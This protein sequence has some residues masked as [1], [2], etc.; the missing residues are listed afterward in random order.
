MLQL[1]VRI[2]IEIVKTDAF[3]IFVHVGSE[4]GPGFAFFLRWS[5]PKIEKHLR[6][7]NFLVENKFERRIWLILGFIKYTISF[8]HKKCRNRVVCTAPISQKTVR[9]ECLALRAYYRYEIKTDYVI[10]S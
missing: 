1:A 9:K 2:K 8:V 4:T 3:N 7:A 5:V 10:Y 6:R